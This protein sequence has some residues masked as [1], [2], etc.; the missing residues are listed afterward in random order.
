VSEIKLLT[1]PP[2]PRRVCPLCEGR[3]IYMMGLSPRPCICCR[4]V[5]LYVDAQ[6]TDPTD[7]RAYELGLHSRKAAS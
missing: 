1:G 3:K 2:L 5:G 7:A 6:F 4:G